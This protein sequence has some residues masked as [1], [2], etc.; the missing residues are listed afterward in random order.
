MKTTIIH[1]KYAANHAC[2]R[3]WFFCQH[4]V[5]IYHGSYNRPVLHIAGAALP[6]RN[7]RHEN[8][9]GM[10]KREGDVPLIIQTHRHLLCMQTYPVTTLS[11]L[12]LPWIFIK[13]HWTTS[14][15]VQTTRKQVRF[16]WPSLE[17]VRMSR[18]MLTESQD[19]S[20]HN[21]YTEL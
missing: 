15:Q 16:T 11:P 4:V 17:N 18:A 7:Y 1:N 2:E 19:D 3:R 9:L 14:F 5:H 6:A 10:E 8:F 13:K 12:L 20:S 21:F